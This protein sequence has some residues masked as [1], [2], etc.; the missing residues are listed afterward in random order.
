MNATIASAMGLALGP[1][2]LCCAESGAGLASKPE[3]PDAHTGGG[4]VGGT[5][6]WDGGDAEDATAVSDGA[7]DGG[8]MD[9]A[10]DAGVELL[11]QQ[12][13]TA[14][15]T[16]RDAL[17]QSQVAESA[18]YTSEMAGTWGPAAASYPV[19]PAPT[20]CSELA[21]K[22]ARVLAVAERYVGLPYEHH[23]IP[24]WDPSSAWPGAEGPGLDCSNFSAWVYNYALG[25]VFTSNVEAQADGSS[26]PGRRLGPDEPLE[27]A[28]LLYIRTEALSQIGHVVLYVDATH[29]IDSTGPGVALRPFSGWYQER[30][31]HARR[32]VE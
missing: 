4:G 14:D 13:L 31:S 9:G 5:A 16:L 29:I 18:W 24:A 17:P 30:Y 3:A 11:C 25:V 23:H 8:A 28:D 12:A 26:A 21:W 22:R 32:V 2:G 6:L 7:L 10:G 19:V 15:F 27:T 1:L 20:G